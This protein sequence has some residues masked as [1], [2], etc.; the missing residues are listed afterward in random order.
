MESFGEIYF[1]FCFYHFYKPAYY[2]VYVF[3]FKKIEC[4]YFFFYLTNK[5]YS[6]TF[7]KSIKFDID[8]VEYFGPSFTY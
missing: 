5:N 2:D 7:L 8:T 6:F 3:F 1:S 4:L